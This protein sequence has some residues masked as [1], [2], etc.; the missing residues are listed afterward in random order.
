[1]IPDTL[2][3]EFID[4][5]DEMTELKEIHRARRA[6]LERKLIA[7]KA[8]MLEEERA[9]SARRAQVALRLTQTGHS[10]EELGRIVG[11]SG[12]FICQLAGKAR[13]RNNA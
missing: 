8:A 7:E 1:M 5:T 13:R 6:E 3:N 4:I 10:L 11:V 12:P 2:I 9:L